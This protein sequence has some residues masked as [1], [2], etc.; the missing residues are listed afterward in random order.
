MPVLSEG[1]AQISPPAPCGPGLA[2]VAAYFREQYVR[3]RRLNLL[4]CE[5]TEAGIWVPSDCGDLAALF[6]GLGGHSLLDLGAGDGVVLA[7][8][9]HHFRVVHGIE[10]SEKWC[11]TADRALSDLGLSNATVHRGD[12]LAASL[13][14]YSVVFISPDAPFSDPLEEKFAKELTGRLVVYCPIYRPRRL[15]LVGAF[16]GRVKPALVYERFD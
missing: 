7:V 8:A 13:A 10:R 9:A 15:R 12:F 4:D 14:G 1:P 5:R 3:R 16:S 11:A 6:S 2:R